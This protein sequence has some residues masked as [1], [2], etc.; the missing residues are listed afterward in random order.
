MGVREIGGIIGSNRTTIS[1][2]SE[3]NSFT[4]A[5]FN[6]ALR[7]LSSC[8]LINLSRV[9]VKPEDGADNAKRTVSTLTIEM[10]EPQACKEE[11]T[12][13]VKFR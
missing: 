8:G 6:A 12:I 10:L 4:N 13:P 9:L 11:K 1:I 7:K 3:K 5:V 2:I